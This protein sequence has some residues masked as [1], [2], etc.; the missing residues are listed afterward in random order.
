MAHVAVMAI[1]H[2]PAP[3]MSPSQPAAYSDIKEMTKVRYSNAKWTAAGPV[4]GQQ[5]PPGEVAMTSLV[6]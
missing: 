1:R 6:A 4:H 5:A 2:T 3:M